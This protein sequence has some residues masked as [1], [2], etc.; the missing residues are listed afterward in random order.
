MLNSTPQKRAPLSQLR[1][2]A[3]E[4]FRLLVKRRVVSEKNILEELAKDANAPVLP[5]VPS[6]LPHRWTIQAAQIAMHTIIK[7][8][9]KKTNNDL[10]KQDNAS[11]FFKYVIS[12]MQEE[13]KKFKRDVKKTERMIKDME[14]APLLSDIFSPLQKYR[15]TKAMHKF[16]IDSFAISVIVHMNGSTGEYADWFLNDWSPALFKLWS[17]RDKKDDKSNN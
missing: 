9:V 7:D 1:N 6:Y 3:Q 4:A 12:R 16:F 17:R 11:E 2:V 15:T 5:G 8:W 10:M 13:E 14:D